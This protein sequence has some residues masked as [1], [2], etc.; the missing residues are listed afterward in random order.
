MNTY[1]SS[2]LG[3]MAVET[4]LSILV[5]KQTD[6]H[7]FR[8]LFGDNTKIPTLVQY[9][10]HFV[11]FQCADGELFFT[12]NSTIPLIKYKS[13]D[14][15]GI[16]TY[17]QVKDGLAQHGVTLG[18]EVKKHRIS[19]S[20]CKLPF[21][22]VY[23]RKNLATT[24]YGILIYPEFLKP[25]MLDS[26]LSRLLTGKF[27]LVQKY[28]K[29]QD[30]YLEINLELKQGRHLKHQD[31]EVVLRKIVETLKARSSEFGELYRNLGERAY[32]RLVFWPYEH[33]EYFAPG[34]K[35]QWVRRT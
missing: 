19:K 1:G 29:N 3:A 24:F 31:E 32:P 35:Q 21:V 7:I 16:L 28:D 9:I 22:Y 14:S 25:A 6:K 10:P 23:E 17:D 5:R 12:G 8:T 33:P 18:T 34:S 11:S 15:G 20:V 27:T 2:E 30:Q 4:P 13:G 26:E